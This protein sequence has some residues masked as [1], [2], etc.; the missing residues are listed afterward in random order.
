[1]KFRFTIMTIHDDKAP[2]FKIVRHANFS[3]V[4]IWRFCIEFSTPIS[5]RHGPQWW[6]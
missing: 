6:G 4:F 2:K 1:M 5:Y 3:I